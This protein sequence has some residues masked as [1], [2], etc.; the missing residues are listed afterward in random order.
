MDVE[1]P[2]IVTPG[3]G[4]VDLNRY[5]DQ[6]D[7]PVVQTCCMFPGGDAGLENTRGQ[8]VTYRYI[9]ELTSD[10]M[11]FGVAAAGSLKAMIDR[12]KKDEYISFRL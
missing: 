8:K 9:Q 11:G 10:Q 7:I 4:V 1:W 5:L 3:D 12:P 2:S 6:R